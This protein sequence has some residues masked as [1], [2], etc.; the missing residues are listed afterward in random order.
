MK[1]NHL[2]KNTEKS[3]NV[4]DYPAKERKKIIKKATEEANKKQLELVEKYY[5]LHC[6]A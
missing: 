4:F 1:L 3:K 6:N 5:A 2:M